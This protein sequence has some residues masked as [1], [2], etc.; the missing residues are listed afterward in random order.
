[1]HSTIIQMFNLRYSIQVIIPDHVENLFSLMDFA[2]DKKISEDE[3]LKATTHYRCDTNL[4]MCISQLF[5][6]RRKLGH[7]MTISLMEPRRRYMQENIREFMKKEKEER[8]RE[9]AE[10]EEKKKKERPSLRKRL[11]KRMGSKEG[12]GSKESQEEEEEEEGEKKK[13]EGEEGE[14]KKEE[15]VGEEE[16]EKE[17]EEGSKE[18]KKD[19][20]EVRRR[21]SNS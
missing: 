10:E 7:M 21:K 11:M 16:E 6:P 1:M 8:E 20:Q 12:G 5:P 18:L 13:E 15:E 2:H 14:K 4:N 9:E 17:G 19:A 3:F